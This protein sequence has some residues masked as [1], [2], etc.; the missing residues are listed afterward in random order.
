MQTT[1][2]S[3]RIKSSNKAA[4]RSKSTMENILLRFLQ[5]YWLVRKSAEPAMDIFRQIVE[6]IRKCVTK[7][8][9]EELSKMNLVPKIGRRLYRSQSCPDFLIHSNI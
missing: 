3:A 2:S 9:S 1:H 4:R 6:D 8:T 5:K 7:H